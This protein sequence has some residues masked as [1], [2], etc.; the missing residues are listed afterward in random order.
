L[1]RRIVQHVEIE[2]PP[3]KVWRHLTDGT[4]L[5]AWLMPTED[6]QA[7]VGHSF[8]FRAVPVGD[9]GEWDGI[10]HCTVR[11][12]VAGRRLSWSWTSNALGA[13]TLVTITLEDL[14]GRTRVT[15][16]HAGWEGLPEARRWL[17]D[18]HDRGW[19]Q[20]LP[21]RLKTQVEER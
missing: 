3:S 15:L 21:L 14:G 7:R 1:N 9:V 13:E 11:E 16:E 2:A 6:F 5:S 4:L 18:E 10:V 19:A 17:I 12:L 20:M 8:T